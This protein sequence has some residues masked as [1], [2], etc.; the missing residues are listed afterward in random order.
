MK[1][2]K[3]P[4][5]PCLAHLV[6]KWISGFQGLQSVLTATERS[7]R[8]LGTKIL[9]HGKMV[10]IVTTTGESKLQTFEEL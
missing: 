2:E 6:T 7:V 8:L 10:N 5:G 9:F 1:R 4:G 3:R